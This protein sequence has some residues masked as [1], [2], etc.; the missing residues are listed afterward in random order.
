MRYSKF[1][2]DEFY[3]IC[4][5]V[6]YLFDSLFFIFLEL[7]LFDTFIFMMTVRLDLEKLNFNFSIRFSKLFLSNC[8]SAC[9]SSN[10]TKCT[11]GLWLPCTGATRVQ[12][13]YKTLNKTATR[14]QCMIMLVLLHWLLFA[15]SLV[16]RFSTLYSDC[17]HI[18]NT[19]ICTLMYV[20]VR[21]NESHGWWLATE[22]CWFSFG[23]TAPQ[24]SKYLKQKEATRSSFLQIYAYK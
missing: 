15:A 16:T 14:G 19:F 6:I 10:W 17:C 4:K 5:S 20:Q 24:R 9:C 3:E 13:I 12:C 23:P 21:R 11:H 8:I 1:D 22:L 7:W 18:H 2:F